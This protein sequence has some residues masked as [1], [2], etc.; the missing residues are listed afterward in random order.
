M[1]QFSSK[2]L[3]EGVSGDDPKYLQKYGDKLSDLT[4]RAQWI[5]TP[6][7]HQDH[8][9]QSLVTRNNDVI[10]QWAEERKA[11]PATVPGTEHDD[12]IGVLR[13]NFEGNARR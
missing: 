12:R 3:P 11:R 2:E 6:D 10:K 9:G 7:Q 1:S 4:R 13:F 5:S 8:N